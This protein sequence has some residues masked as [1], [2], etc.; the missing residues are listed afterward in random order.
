MIAENSI[1]ISVIIPVYN[2][3]KFLERCLESIINQSLKELEIICVNDG[4]TDKSAEILNNYAKK[5]ERIRVLNQ[6]KCG[7]SIA[8]NLGIDSA[9]GKFIG[10]VDSDDYIDFNFYE[11]LYKAA[12]ESN[13]DMACSGIVRKN[14]K[15]SKVI[16]RYKNKKIADSLEKKIELANIPECCYVWNK[17]YLREKIMA[18]GI[19]FKEGAYYEDL[20]FTPQAMIYL[21]RL[22]S[23]PDITYHYWK[24][25][26]SVI[27][28][29]TDKTR[30]DKLIANK[31]LRSILNGQGISIENKLQYKKDYMFMGIK[32]LKIY[33][34]RATKKFYLFGLLPFLT[35]K[36]YI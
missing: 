20:I 12:T 34:Y 30:S 10:F 26:D 15:K 13:A 3:E 25:K 1:K 24:H 35:V 17:I 29:D 19:K 9:N 4:S 28:M 18:S 6:N 36:E 33:K 31:E 14:D 21:G 5:D 8:R 16:L 32:L 23:V 2:S 7:L 22:V 27:K 11:K